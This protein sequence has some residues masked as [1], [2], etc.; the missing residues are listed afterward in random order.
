MVI[1]V[2]ICRLVW[3]DSIRCFVDWRIVYMYT[4]THPNANLNPKAKII[5]IPSSCNS[6]WNDRFPFILTCITGFQTGKSLRG[7]L[8]FMLIFN[9]IVN[10]K[11]HIRF[12][13]Y[14]ASFQMILT[15]DLVT[16]ILQRINVVV[17][18]TLHLFLILVLVLS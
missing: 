9:L 1:L 7:I 11:K 5:I 12:Q 2:L 13:H 14:F 15:F 17:L 16:H 8:K 4:V 6:G 18:V 3:F 10:P